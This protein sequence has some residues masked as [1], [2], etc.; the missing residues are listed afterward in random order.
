MTFSLL[1]A[2]CLSPRHR[3]ICCVHAPACGSKLRI[4]C[5]VLLYLTGSDMGQNRSE[6][7][8]DHKLAS[9]LAK[10]RSEN[11]PTRLKTGLRFSF[12]VLSLTVNAQP[13]FMRVAASEIEKL[14]FWVSK[15]KKKRQNNFGFFAQKRLTPCKHLHL[16]RGALV[17]F[18]FVL[19][20]LQLSVCLW[21]HD[22][23]RDDF[24]TLKGAGTQ[25]CGT[26]SF[27]VRFVQHR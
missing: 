10:N 9:D 26:S 20:S 4:Q 25:I 14:L 5:C 12:S 21:W 24:P 17:L 16:R 23:R 13:A 6:N 3:K 1:L 15:S 22:Y 19:F 27:V 2:C 18:Y 7:V 8:G 11:S